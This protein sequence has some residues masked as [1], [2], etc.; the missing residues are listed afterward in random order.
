MSEWNVFISYATPSPLTEQDLDTLADI[1]ETWNAV[2]ANRRA[3]TGFSVILHMQAKDALSAAEQG[4]GIA[5]DKLRTDPLASSWTCASPH[6]NSSRPKHCVLTS[7]PS[8]LLP[9][10]QRSLACPGSGCT[11]SPHPTRS[12]PPPWRE[13]QQVLYGPSPRSNTSTGSGSASLAAQFARETPKISLL[14]CRLR[15]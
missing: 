2:V 8:P 10:P 11:N 13:S 12:S 5:R 3:G 6:L 14:M 4:V 7:R 9:T 1:A 15:H